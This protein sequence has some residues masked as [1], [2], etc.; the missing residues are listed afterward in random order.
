VTRPA[1][2]GWLSAIR[3]VLRQ[4]GSQIPR[5]SATDAN[6]STVLPAGGPPIRGRRKVPFGSVPGLSQIAQA[7]SRSPGSSILDSAYK[8]LMPKRHLLSFS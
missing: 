1:S 7:A 6:H 5:T 3:G 4:L 8:S 2:S